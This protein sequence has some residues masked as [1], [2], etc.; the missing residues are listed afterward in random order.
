MSD[1][2]PPPHDPLTNRRRVEFEPIA[3]PSAGGQG[4]ALLFAAVVIICGALAAYMYF[5][6]H[7]PLMDMRV[8]APVVGALWFG[9]R[10]FMTLTPKI[11]GTN[12]NARR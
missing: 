9:V 7:M 10:L 8:I 1:A 5:V 6:Q 11:S 12:E 3:M 2:N 4:K